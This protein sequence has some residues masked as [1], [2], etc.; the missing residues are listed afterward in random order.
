MIHWQTSKEARTLPSSFRNEDRS[1][2]EEQA[3]LAL[4]RDS[5]DRF[6]LRTPFKTNALAETFYSLHLHLLVPL[7]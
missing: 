5:L 3:P 4:T 6:H 2:T 1:M 7:I